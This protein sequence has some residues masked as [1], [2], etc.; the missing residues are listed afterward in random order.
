MIV[1]IFFYPKGITF[2]WSWLSVSRCQQLCHGT[3]G[4]NRSKRLFSSLPSFVTCSRSTLPGM[5]VNKSLFKLFA[6]LIQILQLGWLTVQ[7][8]FGVTIPTTSE[9]T[10]RKITVSV[11]P[12]SW[13]SFIIQRYQSCR[14]PSSC[15]PDNWRRMAQLPSCVSLGL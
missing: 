12:K 13:F 9:S 11:Q 10:P 3:I 6:C 14:K 4:A 15:F 2:L 1:T 5:S 8:T 7:P